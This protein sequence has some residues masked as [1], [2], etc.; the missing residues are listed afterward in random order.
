MKID[1]NTLNVLKNFAKINPSILLNEGNILKTISPN[2]TIMAKATVTTTFTKRC[3]IY[4]LDRFI[5][6]LSLFNDPDLVFNDKFVAVSDSGK[7]SNYYYA[8]EAAIKTPPERE[9]KI[10]SI[11]VSVSIKDTDLR[12]AEKAAGVLQLPEIF[13]SGNGST[14]FLEAGD[15]KGSINDKFSIEIGET[16]KTFR[17]VFKLENLKFL[18]G[19]YTV[20]ISSKGISQFTTDNLEYFV[21]VE[22]TSTF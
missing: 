16:N 14:V 17:A 4:N 11:D 15:V 22:S 18:P 5:S 6:T 13:I 21:A 12:D 9:I 1:T 8:D 19:N 2:K 3:A 10:P 20:N 7:T